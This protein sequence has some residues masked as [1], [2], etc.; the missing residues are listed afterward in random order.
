MS[1]EMQPSHSGF[2]VARRLFAIAFGSV[3]LGAFVSLGVQVRG[4][5]GEHVIVPA[6]EFLL[7]V[8]KHLGSGAIWQVPSLLWIDASDG[9]LLG[10]CI[11]GAI[12]SC[13]VIA[14]VAPGACTFACWVL[15]L[16]LCGVG[17]PFLDFQWD[18]LLLETAL[19]A[20]FWLPWRL[21]PAWTIETY[22]Q[23]FARCLLWWLLFRLMFE[24][25]VVKLAWGD[26][27]W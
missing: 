26:K 11:A 19:L 14:G 21:R 20:A 10:F 5:F 12:L 4:L 9:M 3:F 25:G 6:A 1:G 16:S 23:Q 13:G 17:S 7:Q 22:G 27:T 15:Y 24:S 8:G 18:I 2:C